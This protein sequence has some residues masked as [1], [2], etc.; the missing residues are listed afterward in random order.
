MDGVIKI[1]LDNDLLDAE[2]IRTLEPKEV[3]ISALLFEP[4]SKL[5][6]MGT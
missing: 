5:I 4:N 6:I 3:I 1:T 2:P